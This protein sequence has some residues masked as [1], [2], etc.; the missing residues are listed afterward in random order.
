M[1]RTFALTAS[2]V[3]L[4]FGAAACTGAK[5][6]NNAGSGS[7]NSMQSGASGSTQSGASNSMQSASG[8]MESMGG[9]SSAKIPN[10]GAVKAV[11]ANVSSKVYHEPGDPYYGK[12]KHGM[13]L[14]PSQAKAEGYRA[15]GAKAA[16]Q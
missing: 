4:L 13:Y 6:N 5:S 8:S 7:S 14:C 12:T 1:K 15:S 10:C 3:W 16:P 2:L 11:W 9:M